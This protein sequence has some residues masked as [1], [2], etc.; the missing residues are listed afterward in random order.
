MYASD[1]KSWYNP[2]ILHWLASV[3][4]VFS[5]DCVQ[6]CCICYDALTGP[7]SYGEGK[8]GQFDVIQLNKCSHMFHRLCLLAM[9]DSSHNVSPPFH[10]P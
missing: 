10:R 1:S 9:Y 5:A 8:A 7:S 3:M 4:Y 2:L 6:D